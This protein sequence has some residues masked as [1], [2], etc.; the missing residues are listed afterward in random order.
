MSTPNPTSAAPTL[1]EIRTHLLEID[2]DL[3]TQTRQPAALPPELLALEKLNT[4]LIRANNVLLNRSRSLFEAL[5]QADLTEETGKTVLAQLKTDLNTHLQGLDEVGTVDGQG[6][7]SYLTQIAGLGALEQQAKLDVRDY[8]LAPAEQ[9]MIEDCSRGPDFRPGM[10][11]LTFSYQDQTV[12]F[13]GAF[14]LTRKASPVVADLTSGQSVG[15]VLLFT[16]N[17]GLEAFDSLAELDQ[18]LKALLLLPAGREEFCRHLPVRYQALDVASIWPLHLLP[19]EG[20][21]L[22]EHT[23]NALLDKRSQDIELAL[24]LVNN[25]SHDAATLKA[26]LDSAVKAAL[27]D[28]SSRLQFRRQQLLERSLYN[29]LPD[30]YRSADSLSQQTLGQFIRGY[31]QA[32]SA[33]LDL[34]G[35]VASPQALASHQ[36][37]EYLDEEL[38]LYNLDLQQLQVT[39]R[40][41]VA[42]VGTYEQQRSLADLSYSGLHIDDELAGSDF[43]TKTTVTYAGSAFAQLNAQSLLGIL[44]E[45]GY[46]P[47]L[48]F[49]AQ[50]REMQAMPAFKQAARNLFDQRL[51]LLAYVA[52]LRGDLSAADYQ[53]FEDLRGGTNPR[54]CAQTVLLHGAQLRDLWLLREDDP[55]GQTQRLLLCTPGS[56]RERQFMAFAS[57]RE[58]QTHIIGWA[59]DNTRWKGR[60]LRDYVLEQC[61]L[62][63]RPKMGTFLAGLGFKP[64][65]QE[66]TEVTFGPLCSHTVCLDAMAVHSQSAAQDDYEYATPLWYRS[67]SAADRARLTRL[68]E[69]AAGALRVYN[70]RPDSEANFIAFNTYVHQQATLSL[71]TLLGRSQNDIDPDTLFI[72]AP[73]PLLGGKPAPISYTRLY[74][75]G[76]QDN[77]GFID[78]KFSTSATFSGPKGVDLSRLTAQNVSRSVTGVW[79]GQR[80]IDEVRSTLQS[81]TSPGYAERRNATLAI[82]QLQIKYAAL[83]GCLR[84][85]I[86]RADLAWLERAIDS[87]GDTTTAT[88]NTYRV[89][90]LM[91]D[92]EWVIGNYLFSH[93]DN[94]V[95]LYTPNAPDG[96]AVRE[97]KLFN[98]WLKKVEGVSDYLN[99]RVGT[100]ATA[101][102]K[103]FLATARKG[104]PETIDRT[105]PSP[106]RHD[107]IAHATPLTDLRHELYNMVLQRK[108]DDVAATTV[109]RTAMITGILWTCVE[110]VTAIVTIPFPVLSL[111]LGSLLAFKDAMLAIHAYQ[112][113]DS[114]GAL[115]HFVG[116]LANL[117]GAVL[118]DFRP[119]LKGPFS[120]FSIRPA[121]KALKEAELIAA[122]DPR[123][124]AD[125]KP[126]LFEGQ[127]F[128]TRNTPDALGRHLL[129]RYDP[130][131]GQMHST[132]R[133]VNQHA[134]GRWL[135]SGVAGG[136]R[137]KYQALQEE[138]VQ[139]LA[140]YEISPEQGSQFRVA[141]DTDF[142]KRFA[143]PDN[144]L[145]E[146]ARENV[147][148]RLRGLRDSYDNQV[149]QLTEDAEALFAAPPARSPRTD[150]P[151][152]AADSSP[153]AVL[154]SLFP[155]KQRLIIG[156]ANAGVVSKQLLIEDMQALAA[157]G[158]KRLYIENLPADVFRTK[159]RI[160]NG[161]AKGDLAHALKRVEDHLARVD[162]ALGWDL[163]AP[164]T[165]R[166]LMLEAHQH[167]VAIEGVDASS[168]YHLEHVLELSGAERFVPRSGKLRNFYSHKTL[169]AQEP[170]E[171]W[172]ALVDHNRIGGT[173]EVP[174]LADLQN[175]VALRVDEGAPGQAV[176]IQ[177]DTSAAALSRGDYRLTMAPVAQP[178]PVAGPSTAVVDLA[179]PSHYT[180]FDLPAT[181]KPQL[182]DMVHSH[183]DLDSR[184]GFQ[185]AHPFEEAFNTFKRTRIR[186]QQSAKAAF[187]TYTPP[188]R[189]SFVEL[190]AAT[191]EETFIKQVYKLKLGL[192]IAEAHADRSSKRFLINYMKLLKEQGVKTLYLEHLLTDL[193]QLELEAFYSTLKM[194]DNLKR[195]LRAQDLGHMP[196]G[197][198]GSDTYTNVVKAANKAGIRVRALDCTASYHV[199]GLRDLSARENLFSYFANEVIKADQAAQG[200]HKWV[201]LM[202]TAHADMYQGV[203]GIAQLQDAVSLT[204]RDVAPDHARPLHRGAWEI[205]E[206]SIKTPEGV[207]LRSDFKVDVGIAGTPAPRPAPTADRTWLR[208]V[209]DFMIER[210]STTQANVLHRSNTGGII[211]TP[212]QIDDSGQFFIDRW[213]Q[214]QG[215]RY[216]TLEFLV[217][218]LKSQVLLT[219]VSAST[220]P[221][222]RL[223]N[224]GDFLIEYASSNQA[225][226]LHR[227]RTGDIVT[228]PIQKD[229]TGHLF[230]ER[231]PPLKGKRYPTIDGLIDALK[232]E[233][234]LTAVA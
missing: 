143:S 186:L 1:Q 111:G 126:V 139:P 125:M 93:G 229:E 162:K 182:D 103:T 147:L 220:L 190:A 181:L 142:G 199:K 117:G 171:G 183:R 151:L 83:D 137:K 213:P 130:L 214:V 71:N 187:A 210:P 74:R 36:L 82:N 91:L 24:S 191:N 108:I 230:I 88:R 45:P 98:Y 59:D 112:Q 205:L 231:W 226:L 163:D 179:S 48:D 2:P 174:G 115:Q 17:R 133:L 10:Y 66:H 23:Y 86:A 80:Y 54:L 29:S 99:G 233:V 234:Y 75:D 141:L 145:E 56:P 150:L 5:T 110:L 119:A 135:R 38:E 21:P 156:A 6:R 100:G 228:T 222:V 219:A 92:G 102:I 180:A 19:I 72:T 70:A 176:G 65:A 173:D 170:Q 129:Y 120:T 44:R 216:A 106:A 164:F 53:L 114:G 224:I 140:R 146:A 217:H 101:R 175:V 177:F 204:V 7:K 13:A 161:Q 18:R 215:Q 206:K 225:N 58:C 109:N 184:Y 155:L 69:D 73:W 63:F 208:S 132:A 34:L 211:S 144:A 50:Q 33:Y 167:N 158:L 157:L 194:P 14:V 159:L 15:Q 138:A 94:P 60:T 227:S 121:A 136:G 67:A 192:I 46:Q 127:D 26:A 203:P 57:E 51:A 107:P 123:L 124:P 165:F 95:L 148:T 160:I 209:G 198:S 64:D 55:Q 116:Y 207:A 84:G 113:G 49:A 152:L 128:W 79:V 96:I 202:G 201:A 77:V 16:P 20:E 169:A 134:D 35:P 154:A 22:F 85:H 153:S 41:H 9:R 47:R 200:P 3:R 87:L 89:H 76:Y 39:T 172:I 68:G 40:R 168:S 166:K 62:R 78:P 90:R 221:S 28:L 218:A 232:Q 12:A 42:H 193:H 122:I 43:L 25:P 188:A 196:H 11:S 223:K 30:W 118:F 31:N 178:L 27:P 185:A 4:T 149:K 32:R 104:L 212:V 81:A 97:A 61:P 105:T 52:K 195:Y 189:S 8:L 197:Y 131:T 37:T